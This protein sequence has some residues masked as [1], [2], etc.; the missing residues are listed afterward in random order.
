MQP[1]DTR[2]A[3][4]KNKFI[5]F[6]KTDPAVT[7]VSENL[8]TGEYVPLY[9]NMITVYRQRTHQTDATVNDVVKS[10]TPENA[11]VVETYL[12]ALERTPPGETPPSSPEFEG[13]HFSVVYKDVYPKSDEDI[14]SSKETP[15][16]G[17]NMPMELEDS[18]VT[19]DVQDPTLMEQSNDIDPMDFEDN[20]FLLQDTL[21]DIDD[22]EMQG[23]ISHFLEEIFDMTFDQF[24]EMSDAEFKAKIIESLTPQSPEMSD[25]TLLERRLEK[26]LLVNFSALRVNRALAIVKQLGPKEALQQ[27]KKVDPEVAKQ[28]EF[29]LQNKEK[30]N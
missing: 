19:P 1:P 5:E 23:E 4:M 9:P 2:G 15:T 21:E 30:E 11:S 20:A 27:I 7:G 13:L 29:L 25:T 26:N 3:E 12:T 28:L 22:P 8:F 14:D 16:N 6:W 17:T 24:L 10:A 18:S